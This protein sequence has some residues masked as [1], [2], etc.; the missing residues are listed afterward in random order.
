MTMVCTPY[1][2]VTARTGHALDISAIITLCSPS[3]VRNFTF[4]IG[5]G[6][7][8]KIKYLYIYIYSQKLF[9]KYL[10]IFKSSLELIIYK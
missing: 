6:Y 9:T 2:I 8:K 10:P 4:N 7:W 3:Q 5:E 1:H